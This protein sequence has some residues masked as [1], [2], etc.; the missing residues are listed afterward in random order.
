M[1]RSS[2]HVVWLAEP[3]EAWKQRTFKENAIDGGFRRNVNAPR[4]PPAIPERRSGVAVVSSTGPRPRPYTASQH[5]SQL[6]HFH[7]PPRPGEIVPPTSDVYHSTPFMTCERQ[8]CLSPIASQSCRICWCV[9]RS[10][11]YCSMRERLLC[12]L[13]H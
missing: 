9:W 6:L 10:R 13:R 8:A 7:D 11:S 2:P 3:S 12:K 5:H 4:P 1:I